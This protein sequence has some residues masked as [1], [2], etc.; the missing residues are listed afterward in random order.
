M[1][2]ALRKVSYLPVAINIV[3]LFLYNIIN[4]HY[5]WPLLIIILFYLGGLTSALAIFL[6]H[7]KWAMKII[8]FLTFILVIFFGGIDVIIST[9]WKITGFSP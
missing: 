4:I 8:V 7:E 3:F 9:A 1:V 5:I 6:Q 2:L